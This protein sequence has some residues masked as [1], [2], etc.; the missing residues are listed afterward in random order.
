MVA[1]EVQGLTDRPLSP[2][3]HP[4]LV[5][6]ATIQQE[7]IQFVEIAYLRH[8]HPVVAPE[9][10]HLAL[11]AALL[12]RSLFA[13]R[14]ELGVEAVVRAEGDEARRLF[15]PEAPQDLLHRRRQVV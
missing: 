4:P 13:R 14:A 15:A 5:L 12:V 10:A 1:L 7:D 8:R 2:G 9:G 11:D 6:A 3:Q